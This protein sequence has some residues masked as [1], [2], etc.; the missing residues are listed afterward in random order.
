MIPRQREVYVFPAYA[1]VIL[2][3]PKMKWIVVG[4]SRI[5]G[6]DPMIAYLKTS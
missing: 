6:G 3:N 2:R 5:R 4:L 1:G